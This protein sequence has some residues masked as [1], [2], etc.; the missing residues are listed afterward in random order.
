MN[1]NFDVDTS[2]TD[3]DQLDNTVYHRPSHDVSHG[4]V[5]QKFNP[6]H[7][8]SSISHSYSSSEHFRSNSQD[9][10]RL[11][12]GG[13]NSDRGMTGNP[14]TGIG[15]NS[16]SYSFGQNSGHSQSPHLYGSDSV[17]SQQ[18]W[19]HRGSWVGSQDRVHPGHAQKHQYSSWSPPNDSTTSTTS[20]SSNFFPTLNTPFYPNQPSSPPFV[21]SSN[22]QQTTSN[23]QYES[24][25]S[26]QS[27]DSGP[28]SYSGSTSS[29]SGNSYSLRDPFFQR[30]LPPM[31]LSGYSPSQPLTSSG[32]SGPS[33]LWRD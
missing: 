13:A 16:I 27:R 31:Q 9:G 26:L 14:S 21:A 32:N 20:G 17:G 33:P 10:H 4:A 7:S 15:L 2:P 23:S 5:E 22:P 25:S 30:T 18:G 8:R 28:R 3:D 19:Q 1:G 12:Y 6:H 11:P 24:V 29:S